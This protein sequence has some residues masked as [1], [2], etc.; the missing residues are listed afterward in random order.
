MGRRRKSSAEDDVY[1]ILAVLFLG[2]IWLYAEHLVAAVAITAL[3][4]LIGFVIWDY[5]R[6]RHKAY[7]AAL[8]EA[9]VR[10]PLELTGHQFE[11]FC[12]LLLGNCGWSVEMTRAT[13]DYGADI[14]ARRGGITMAVQCKRYAGSVGVKAIQEVHGAVA[15]YQAHR[16]AVMSTVG[17]TRA[18][19]NLAEHTGTVLVV[20]G[21]YDPHKILISTS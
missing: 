12:A 21:K 1:G 2:L 8:L 17:F 7:R 11:E 20:P 18:A 14:I 19:I 10:D 5:R 16:S 6:Q 9:G 4:A 3:V 15:Y 13:G